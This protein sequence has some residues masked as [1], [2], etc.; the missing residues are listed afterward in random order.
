MFRTC[1][2]SITTTAWFLLAALRGE[3]AD[4]LPGPGCL[5]GARAPEGGTRWCRVGDR[6]GARGRWKRPF[7]FPILVFAP[8]RSMVIFSGSPCFGVA[9]YH[10]SPHRMI[11][12]SNRPPIKSINPP[13]L[14]HRI[15]GA[16]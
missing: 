14:H 15:R 1:K 6:V 7:D 9:I 10:L 5:T 13:L 11:S 2:S 12:F 3:L 8:F 4:S 16:A